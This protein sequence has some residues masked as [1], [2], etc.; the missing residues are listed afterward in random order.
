[1]AK[2][3]NSGA[4]KTGVDRWREET[5]AAQT[6]KKSDSANDAQVEGGEKS[7]AKKKRPMTAVAKRRVGT[8]VVTGVLCVAAVA[9]TALSPSHI[10]GGL[11]FAGGSQIELTADSDATADQLTSA[12]SLIETRLNSMGVSQYKVEKNTDANSL[13]VKVLGSTDDQ[14]D[15]LSAVAQT[16]KIEFVR[17]DT[18]SD[19]E[20]LAKIDAG[21][22][23]VK[24]EEGSYEAFLDS[25]AIKSISV[26]ASTSYTGYYTLGIEF[27]DEAGQTFSDVTGELATDSGKLAIVMDGVVKTAASVSSQISGGEVSVS[28]FSYAEAYGIKAAFDSGN[29]PVSFTAGDAA[30]A[31]PALTT[32]QTIMAA[33]IA[34]AVLVVAALVSMGTFRLSGLL[35]LGTVVVYAALELGLLAVASAG[36][37]FHATLFSAGAA[38]AGAVWALVSA[39]LFLGGFKRE[40]ALGKTPKNAAVAAADNG[41]AAYW[42]LDAVAV[43][44][45]L[46][47]FFFA[48]VQWQV[49]DAG[50]ALALGVFCSAAIKFIFLRPALYLLA[51]GA[52]RNNPAAWGAGSDKAQATAAKGADADHKAVTSV[53]KVAKAD[54][55]DGADAQKPS[56]AQKPASA[57][58][59]S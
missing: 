36:G 47:V 48:P 54:A 29:L 15:T 1:M 42:Q 37:A 28:G 21:T 53:T 22:E 26:T 18:V 4:Q 44:A 2:K 6:A 38:C 45:G 50:F 59:E 7:A 8:L 41:A 20:A 9:G 11:D 12:A 39:F 33:G 27:T 23:N 46:L 32:E 24:L 3:K 17:V 13:T 25:S 49:R 57:A 55:A 58:K 51:Q 43:A 19:A 10:T 56:D 30:E 14:A 5:H 16:G 40:L 35:A 31:A 34:A 52:I